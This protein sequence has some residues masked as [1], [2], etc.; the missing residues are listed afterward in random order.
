MLRFL[1]SLVTAAAVVALSSVPVH[2]ADALAPVSGSGSPGMH[3]AIDQWRTDTASEL[4]VSFW[5]SGSAAARHDFLDQTVDFAI[6]ELPFQVAPEDGSPPEVPTVSYAYLPIA[7]QGIS[8]MYHLTV[9]GKLLSDLRLP[10]EAVAGIFAGR[11][12]RWNDPSIQVVNPAVRLPDRA[13]RPVYRSDASGTTAQFTR[14]MSDRFPGV[15]TGGERSLFPAPGAPFTGQ[16][17]SLG[18]ASFVS[19]S[20]GEGAITYVENAYAMRTGFPVAKVANAA[21]AFVAPTPEAV[22]VALSSASARPGAVSDL[23]GAYASLDPRA[24]PIPGIASMIVPTQLT[25]IFTTAKGL[26]LQAFVSYAVCAGQQGAA[27]RGDAPLPLNLVRAASDAVSTIPGATGGIDL[28]A[29]ANPTFVA[30]DTPSD[31]ALLRDATFPPRTDRVPGLILESDLTDTTRTLS[32]EVIDRGARARVSAG[33]TAANKTFTVATFAPR[34]SFERV[35]LDATGTGVIDLTAAALAPGTR[36]R[37]YLAE[38]DGTVV[39]WNVLTLPGVDAPTATN[40]AVG[41]T[42]SDLFTLTMP[43]ARAAVDFGDLPREITSIGRGL[44]HFVV[45]DDRSTMSGWTLMLSVADFAGVADPS[46]RIPA[47]ALGYVPQVVDAMSGVTP[48]RAQQ[49]GSATYPAVLASGT[50]N[51]STAAGGTTLDAVFSLR[52]PRATPTGAYR[53]TVTITLIAK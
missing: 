18:V 53:S 38:S 22:S 28:A 37:L 8:L 17:G 11:I 1:A 51:T 3:T 29:C 42:A 40:M 14:W 32:V 15:W 23:S 12:T 21:G 9:D 48:G 20:Y 4:S 13:I 25:K 10:G 36:A 34:R 5:G 41:V 6:S 49:A 52:A 16:S 24:Y 33:A 46:H 19:Q 50:P 47:S 27:A 45:I 2:A 30:G 31:T 26:T 7:A 39:A 35:T 44:G 43:S